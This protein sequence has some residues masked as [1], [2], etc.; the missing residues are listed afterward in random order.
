MLVLFPFGIM[1]FT[2]VMS[3]LFTADSAAQTFTMFCH[4]TII[5]AVST[6]IFLL[7]LAPKLEVLGDQLHWSFKIFPS[8]SIASALYTDSS[9]DF[10]SRIRNE[11]DDFGYRIGEASDISPDPW[12]ILNNTLD[13]ILQGAHFVFW[14]FVLFLIEADLGKRI[15]KCYHSCR[16]R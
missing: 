8:Y 5:L 2:Y 3:F 7:R 11:T 1:P 16:Q 15:G 10:V 4:L 6:L 13:I 12:H 9:I 14:F